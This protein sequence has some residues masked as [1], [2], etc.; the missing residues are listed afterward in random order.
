MDLKLSAVNETTAKEIRLVFEPMM[1]LL[2]EMETEFN[3]LFV[4]GEENVKPKEAKA[5]RLRIAKV[6][7]TAEKAKTE[8]KKEILLKGNAIQGAFNVLKLATQG[9]ENKCKAVEER[10]ARIEA[11][12]IEDLQASRA[13][14]LSEYLDN[15]PDTLGLMSEDVYANYSQGVITSHNLK[16]KA[17]KQ[18]EAD[19]LAKIEAD[20]KERERIE[21]ENEK[22]KAEAEKREAEQAIER[23]RLEEIADKEKAERKRE[24]AKKDKE[25]ADKLAKEQ[26]KVKE[27]KAESDRLKKAE[28]DRLAKIK[29]DKETELNKGDEDKVNDLIEDLKT[30]QLKYTFKSEKNIEMQ[31][32]VNTLLNKVINF[33]NK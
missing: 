25:I 12:R 18:A 16:V 13:E 6:R 2:D 8:A 19:R 30:L 14:L 1:N 27:A 21:A 4:D 20:K 9:K 15:I 17:E 28:A 22:L 11:Q 31:L 32:S 7:T 10:E 29:A 3:E 5:L 33:I 26:Q 23:K 24:Q